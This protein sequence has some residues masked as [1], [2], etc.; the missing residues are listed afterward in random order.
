M[1]CRFGVLTVFLVSNLYFSASY[2][3]IACLLRDV[4]SVAYSFCLQSGM[5]LHCAADQTP[6]LCCVCTSPIGCMWITM[7]GIT[8]ILISLAS[9]FA[10]VIFSCCYCNVKAAQRSLKEQQNDGTEVAMYATGLLINM[11]SADHCAVDGNGGGVGDGG[12]C[13]GGA[14]VGDGFA[15]GGICGGF[16]NDGCWTIVEKH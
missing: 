2:S 1:H 11:T 10:L 14:C 13:D 4:S 8:I 15:D 6:F 3:H 5:S 12:T 7:E 16:W 9:L